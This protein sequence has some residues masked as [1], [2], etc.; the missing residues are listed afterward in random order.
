MKIFL[1]IFVLLLSLIIGVISLLPP[2]EEEQ[3]I[4]EA[5]KTPSSIEEAADPVTNDTHK[6]IKDLLGGAALDS[7]KKA[8]EKISEV[9]KL[10]ENEF[11]DVGL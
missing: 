11:E 2:D 7:G 8:Q 1:R 6:V 9:N 5:S 3:T 4:T 10:R